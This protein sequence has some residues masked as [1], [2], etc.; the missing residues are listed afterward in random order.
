MAVLHLS[1]ADF[2]KEVLE[3]HIPVLVDFYTTWCGPCKTMSPI[4]EDA[5]K[6]YSERLKVAKINVEEA[7]AIASQYSIMSVPTLFIFKNAKVVEQITGAVSKNVLKTK[8][9]SALS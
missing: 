6:E 4:I 9:E 8:I 5:A 2:K 1:E 3:S 7:G